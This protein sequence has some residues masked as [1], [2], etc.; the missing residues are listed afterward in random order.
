MKRFFFIMVALCA[1]TAVQ[2]QPGMG[3]MG[4]GMRMGGGMG[5]GMGGGMM[6]R[7]GMMPGMNAEKPFY[8][9]ES[10]SI[11]QACLYDLP[12]FVDSKK[13]DKFSKLIKMEYEEV[14]RSMQMSVIEN[15]LTNQMAA[16]GGRMAG[17]GYG[18]AGDSEPKDLDQEAIRKNVDGITAKYA[19]KYRKMLEPDQFEQWNVIQDK[20][21]G[22]GMGYLLAHVFEN[23]SI[24][25]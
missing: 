19:K 17:R 23:S 2:A 15:L 22:R 14:C 20:R 13:V 6:M 11:V 21:Y 3:G 10:D 24:D 16:N 12:F 1:M 25:F 5:M 18:F 4:G 9:N 7:G 8:Q